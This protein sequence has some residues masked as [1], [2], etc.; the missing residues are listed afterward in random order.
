MEEGCAQVITKAWGRGRVDNFLQFQNKLNSCSN[1]LVKWSRKFFPNSKKRIEEL[2]KTLQEVQDK[3]EVDEN[4]EEKTRIIQEIDENWRKEEVYWHQRSRIKWLNFGDKN[5]KNFHQTT[6]QK[7]AHYKILRIKN[8]L[9]EWVENES[10]IVGCFNRYFRE[11]F[12]SDGANNI[13]EALGNV[14]NVLDDRMRADLDLDIEANEVKRAVFQLGAYKAR[15]PDGY[16]GLFYQSQWS[17][18]GSNLISAVMNFFTTGTLPDCLNSTD[19]ILIPKVIGPE[20]PPN[21][22]LYKSM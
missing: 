17:T 2:Q 12:Q 5:S 3:E 7:R 18:I 22:D 15:G 19:I 14:E 9:G 1:S 8:E 6:L 10:E 11:L 4:R 21:L 20:I 13:E 16:N